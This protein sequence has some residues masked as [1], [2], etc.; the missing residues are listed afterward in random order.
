MRVY[1]LKFLTVLLLILLPQIS[2]SQQRIDVQTFRTTALNHMQN[3]RYGEAIDQLNKYITAIPQEPEGYN[4]RATCF[5]KRQQYQYAVLDY[6]WAI[7][8]E[9]QS[10]IKRAEYEDSSI[11][12]LRL[13][14]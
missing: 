7:A 2:K 12:S 3:G 14:F 4:L 10:A 13:F 6:R 5:E 9:T 11:E 8:L 1:S